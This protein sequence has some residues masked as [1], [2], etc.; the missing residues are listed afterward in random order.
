M[1]S[2][3]YGDKM[4]VGITSKILSHNIQRN[5]LRILK[6]EGIHVTEQEND[7][8]GYQEKKLG[9]MQK[10]M[11]IFTF[12]CIAAVVISWVVNLMLP[13]GFL[14]AGFVSGGVLCTWLFV[15]VGYKKR[16]NLL[17]NGMWQLLLISAA[18][19]LWDVFTGWHGWAVDFV[20]RLHRWSF[21]QQ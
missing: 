9:L 10:S 3:S 8:P 12:L 4:R 5:F 18:G 11:Q 20:P 17:K 13:S 16:R 21:L 19:L 7:F 6:E 15:M 2:C 14:W 1:C